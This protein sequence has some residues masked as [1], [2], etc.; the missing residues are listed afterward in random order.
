MAFERA[1]EPVKNSG[2]KSGR[3]KFKADDYPFRIKDNLSEVT[4]AVAAVSSIGGTPTIRSGSTR[5]GW[6]VTVFRP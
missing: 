2:G 1:A 3:V 6:S 5:I 4:R